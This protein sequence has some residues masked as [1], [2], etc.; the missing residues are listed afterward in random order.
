[1][2]VL[3]R[4]IQASTKPGAWILDPF[5]GSSTTGIAAN[6]LGR[7]FLGIEQ[8][9]KFLE[10]SRARREELNSTNRRR[11]ILAKLEKQAK[12]FQDGDIRVLNEPKACYGP[13]LPF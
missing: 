9:E 6:L 2:C 10:M 12:L 4:I 5:T 13:E 8:E 11:E 3:S 1:M 7:R